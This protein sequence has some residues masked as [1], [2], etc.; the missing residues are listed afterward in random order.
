MQVLMTKLENE[1]DML[2]DMLSRKYDNG[3]VE[4]DTSNEDGVVA[5]AKQQQ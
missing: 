3:A 5:T 2:K 4:V 1:N